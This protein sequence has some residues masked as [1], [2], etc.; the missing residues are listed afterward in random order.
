MLDRC[1]QLRSHEPLIRS[2]RMNY[3]ITDIETTI[4]LERVVRTENEGGPL[5]VSLEDTANRI[6]T[7]ICAKQDTKDQAC[8]VPARFH[9]P[10]VVTLL[11]VD[12]QMRYR[13]HLI[14]AGRDPKDVTRRAWSAIQ[15]QLGT[16]T[17]VTFNG[18]RFDMPVLEVCALDYGVQIPTWF[19]LGV[20]PWE[21]IR[22]PSYAGHLDLFSYLSSKASLGGSLSFWSR[23]AGMPG[24]VT[25][26][27]ASVA[28]VLKKADGIEALSDYCTCDV[29]NTY[30]LL[31]R[32]L[33]CAGYL[34]ADYRGPI[35]EDTL[36]R[37]M[38][39]RGPEVRAFR[40]LYASE[41]LF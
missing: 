21:D 33:Y 16:S 5:G 20:K 6:L 23:T 13:N 24:K 27:G 30:G 38:A 9:A 28:E 7:E 34:A 39:G 41:G 1:C 35:F 17:L 4:D 2:P 40:D 11:L 8:F 10:V 31:F 3:L 32:L 12:E 15:A 18:L 36:A 26:T 25:T 29:L 14:V 19:K 37:M 22:H